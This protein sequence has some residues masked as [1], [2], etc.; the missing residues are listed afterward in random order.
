MIDRINRFTSDLDF[1]LD[2]IHRNN[3]KRSGDRSL[4]S[5]QRRLSVRRFAALPGKPAFNM[6]GN[7]MV[8]RGPP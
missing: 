7:V 3:L 2:D 4:P 1:V 5:R 6:F 8:H